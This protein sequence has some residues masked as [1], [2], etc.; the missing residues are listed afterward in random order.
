MTERKLFWLELAEEGKATLSNVE[1]WLVK[2]DPSWL[3]FIRVSAR[4]TCDFFRLRQGT[5]QGPGLLFYRLCEQVGENNW[6]TDLAMR[7]FCV[8]G[9]GRQLERVVWQAPPLCQLRLGFTINLAAWSSYPPHGFER[10][11]RPRGFEEAFHFLIDHDPDAA[12]IAHYLQ[13]TGL[14]LHTDR[15]GLQARLVHDGE[16]LPIQ[17]GLHAV[18]ACPGCR[19]GYVWAYTAEALP[20]KTI[21]DDTGRYLEDA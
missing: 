9:Y 14:L 10:N 1:G 6:R 7:F 2:P 4:P 20:E 17:P 15:K 11:L 21:D 16:T 5:V 13:P 18:A 19:I 12:R 3:D 8:N